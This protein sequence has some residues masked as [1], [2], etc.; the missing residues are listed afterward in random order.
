[1]KGGSGGVLLTLNNSINYLFWAMVAGEE[2]GLHLESWIKDFPVVFDIDQGAQFVEVSLA[3]TQ[4]YTDPDIN[5]C[6][7][8]GSSLYDG[9]SKTYN[10]FS[11]ILIHGTILYQ[12]LRLQKSNL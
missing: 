3:E 6:L 11:A 9:E 12:L 2:V 1:M 10:S 4:R 7:P 5:K 8:D